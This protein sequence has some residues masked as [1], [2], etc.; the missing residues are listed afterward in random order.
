M[1][2]LARLSPT[3]N[4]HPSK[5]KYIQHTAYSTVHQVNRRWP[6]IA[7]NL[8]RTLIGFHR[9]FYA[10]PCGQ[11]RQNKTPRHGHSI[12]FTTFIRTQAI[13]PLLT[14]NQ[15]HASEILTLP[16]HPQP[17]P[18]RPRALSPSPRRCIHSRAAA[19]AWPRAAAAPPQQ[20]CT[21]LCTTCSRR[22]HIRRCRPRLP[23][24]ASDAPS[25]QCCW[26]CWRWLERQ[27]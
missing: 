15:H 8:P 1:S 16:I 9:T 13:H 26:Q 12:R 4:L 11:P 27:W 17:R 7:L 10:G 20:C 25:E 6:S 5:Q 24:H 3:P 19:R 14:F 22:Q 2:S 21:R 18:R 23:P